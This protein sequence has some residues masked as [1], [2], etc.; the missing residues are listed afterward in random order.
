MKVFREACRMKERHPQPAPT[1]RALTPELAAL[2]EAIEKET[3]P[4]RLAD[5]AR[6]LQSALRARDAGDR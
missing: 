1:P 6:R 5:L 3:V 4:D 2:L